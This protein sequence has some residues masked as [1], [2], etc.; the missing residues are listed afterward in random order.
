MALRS[1]QLRWPGRCVLCQHDLPAGTLA[2]FDAATH[3]ISCLDCP[4]TPAH[5]SQVRSHE[6]TEAERDRLRHLIGDARA[7]LAAA[8]RAG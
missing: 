7:A 1:I 6:S 3:E 5:R 8:R 4:T 2:L